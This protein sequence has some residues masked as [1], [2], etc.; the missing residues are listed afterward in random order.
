LLIFGKKS[1]LKMIVKDQQNFSRRAD[2]AKNS[3]IG[4]L[5]VVDVEAKVL[6]HDAVRP[7]ISDQI[8]NNCIAALDKYDA[9]YVAI[10]TADTIIVVN[11][12]LIIEDI[13]P[14]NFL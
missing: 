9:V 6:I 10:P 5:S 4:V 11:D 8:I 7:L 1:E 3:H 2:P 14:A 12:D 13:A